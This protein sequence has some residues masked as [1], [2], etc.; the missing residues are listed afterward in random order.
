MTSVDITADA[1]PRIAS[2]FRMQF[3]PAQD[4]SVLL[5][6]E[7]MVTLNPSAAEILTRCDGEKS[8]AMLCNELSEAFEGVNLDQDVH[9]FLQL[10]VERGWVVLV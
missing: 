5:Y 8:V 7:G 10:A 2:G 3:E 1:V 9:E 4:C 6:P